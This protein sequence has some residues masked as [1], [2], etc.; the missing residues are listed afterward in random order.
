MQTHIKNYLQYYNI[1]QEQ[2]RCEVCWLPAS[3]IH[4]IIAR[5]KFGKKTKD[6]QVDEVKQCPTNIL[7]IELYS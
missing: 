5:S 7:F 6:L 1:E 3:D 4:H 2:A